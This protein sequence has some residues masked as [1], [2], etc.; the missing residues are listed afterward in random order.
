M[1][2]K[3]WTDF[4]TFVEA[5]IKNRYKSF[6][7]IVLDL[8]LVFATTWLALS[9]R[10]DTEVPAR[11]VAICKSNVLIY[12]SIVLVVNTGTGLYRDV[13]RYA[14]VNEIIRV[15]L[16][17]ALSTL[18]IYLFNSFQYQ[19]LPRSVYL[20]FL[21]LLFI[22]QSFIRIATIYL[23][24]ALERLESKN[25][26][27]SRV[28]IVGA[29]HE[30]ARI[31]GELLDNMR[32][33]KVPIGF[34]DDDVTMLG[35][36][37]NSVP[38][39]GTIDEIGEIIAKKDIDE[40]I[41][42]I[43]SARHSLIKDIVNKCSGSNCRMRI[44]PTYDSFFKDKT[45]ILRIRDIQIEDLLGRDEID[46]NHFAVGSYI[47]DKKVLVTG[48]GGSIGSELC[49]QLAR[50]EP[51]QLIIVDIYENNAHDIQQELMRENSFITR[52][53]LKVI[54]TSICDEV[55]MDK[56]FESYKPDLVFHAAAHKHVPLMEFSPVEAVKNN[57]FGTK[58]VADI[59]HKYGVEKFIL[60]S[61]DKAVN[62]T[63]IMGATKRMSELIIQLL[64]RESETEFAAVRFGNVLGSDGSVIPLFTK[65]IKA[66]G[67]VTVTDPNVTRYFM[68]IPEAVSLLLQ[69]GALAGGGEV[70]VF[71]MGDP[72]KIDD[73]A[74]NLIRLSGY[75]PDVDIMIEYIG[76]RP[77]EKLYEELLLSEEGIG[78][79][80]HNMIFVGHPLKIQ[81]DA[82]DKCLEDLKNAE[83][84]REIDEIIKT[85]VTTYKPNKGDKKNK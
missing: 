28:L 58:V 8:A 50:L 5:F 7:Y 57:V 32:A 63:N 11:Y 41:L 70:F 81:K 55:Q 44:M 34:V 65:Q 3:L 67:P 20:I 71:D 46:I 19:L 47:K 83:N 25:R 64:D 18:G 49:R 84:R 59:S 61:S 48:G 38:V 26:A 79:T 12:C 15:F 22:S 68:T 13:W 66:G 80:T 56:I 73:L 1:I 78:K 43:P 69:A 21:L 17:T 10:F 60:I 42:A 2:L 77:G 4:Q 27:K 51:K 37:I 31:A 23:F 85:V 74:R 62:P 76:L 33:R 75:E 82:L 16:A 14:G 53:S 54:I 45:P 72:V 9:L 40:V 52:D 36:R 6:I 30:G 29:G 24:K 39:L 35:H